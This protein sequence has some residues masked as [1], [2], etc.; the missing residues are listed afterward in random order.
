[1]LHP[2]GLDVIT[3]NCQLKE[4]AMKPMYLVVLAIVLVGGVV[5][6][7][8]YYQDGGYM[9]PAPAMP[10]TELTQLEKTIMLSEQSGLGQ[11]GKA[12]I[13]SNADGKAVVTLQMTGGTFSQSQPAH[14]HV[15]SCPTPGAVK[16]P[17]TNVVNGMS[18]TTLD[19]M[20]DD[21]IKTTDKMAINVHKSAAEASVYTAC[22]DVN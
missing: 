18:E 21:F 3:T 20:Y 4:Y 7:K 22:G 1:M 19:V 10:A 14:V 12:I 2:A 17:L 11:S 8:M 9:M 5:F 6:W 13:N 15:G 16:Y